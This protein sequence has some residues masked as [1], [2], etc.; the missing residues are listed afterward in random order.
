M[1]ITMNKGHG[2]YLIKLI[3]HGAYTHKV[4][5][6]T[7]PQ[8]FALPTIGPSLIL[9]FLSRIFSPLPSTWLH[10]SHLLLLHLIATSAGSPFP[11]GPAPCT[12]QDA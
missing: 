1:D 9:L 11:E 10:P 8:S 5:R 2:P 12:G 6:R 3:H 7:N 4:T